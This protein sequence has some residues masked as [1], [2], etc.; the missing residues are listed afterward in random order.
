MLENYIKQHKLEYNDVT[1]NVSVEYDL[2]SND[3]ETFDEENL[4]VPPP[5]K[6]LA[7]WNELSLTIP[8]SGKTILVNFIIV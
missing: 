7:Y 8:L 2:R 1:V 3:I 6:L 5:M 4:S